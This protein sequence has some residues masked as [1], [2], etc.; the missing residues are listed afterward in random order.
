MNTNLKAPPQFGGDIREQMQQVQR[1]LFQ[2]QRD[3][4][5]ALD[6]VQAVSTG[7]AVE[8]AAKSAV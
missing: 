5:V 2:L 8:G 1:Y 7:K 4:N 3:L 6:S